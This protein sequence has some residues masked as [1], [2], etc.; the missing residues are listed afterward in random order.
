MAERSGWTAKNGAGLDF[1]INEVLCTYNIDHMVQYNRLHWLP[2]GQTSIPLLA[3][4]IYW[5]QSEPSGSH[6][7][8]PTD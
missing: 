7:L 1:S 6:V 2:F 3:T 8:V 5:K 4:A